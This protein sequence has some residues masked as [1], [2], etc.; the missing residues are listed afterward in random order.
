VPSQG[1]NSP[2]TLV[3]DDSY[4]MSAWT[5][6]SQAATSDDTYA[7][8]DVFSFPAP[9]DTFYLKATNFSFSIP[10]GAT[11]D[12]ILVEI[13]K[14]KASGLESV[15][16]RQ[17]RIVKGGTIGSTEKAD[18]NPWTT[19]DTYVSYGGS[20][21]LWGESWSASDIN[22]SDFG[23]VLSA[24][25]DGSSGTAQIDHFRITVYYTEGAAGGGQQKAVVA[26]AVAHPSWTDE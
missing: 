12:G 13:E 11:I 10:G 4:G 7:T 22:A 9:I 24:G 20:S 16:D 15:I 25:T 21:D 8:A 23:V 19:T 18:A 3:E 2:G 5:D 6:P 1:P 17:V 14:S 26:S